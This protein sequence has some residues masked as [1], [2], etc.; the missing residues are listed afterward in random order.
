LRVAAVVTE[1]TPRSHAHVIL[2]NF[3]EPYL[4]NGKKTDSRMDVV[5]LYVDQFPTRD[6]ARDGDRSRPKSVWPKSV[7]GRS[8]CRPKSGPNTTALS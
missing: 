6:L 7:S 5:S 1:F 2:E 8:R 3:L 4:F